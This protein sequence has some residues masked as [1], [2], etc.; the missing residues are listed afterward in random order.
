MAILLSRRSSLHSSF[1]S[2][3]ALQITNGRIRL[4]RRV[5][6]LEDREAHG[7]LSA[8]SSTSDM[9]ADSNGWTALPSTEQ[10]APGTTGR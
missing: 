8:S 6:L 7:A 9:S 1:H 2:E 4:S 3:A 10:S 5:A